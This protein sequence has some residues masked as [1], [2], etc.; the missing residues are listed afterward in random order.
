[1][2]IKDQQKRS[3]KQ[4][5]SSV[6]MRF[7]TTTGILAVAVV[8]L[9]I[10]FFHTIRGDI[11]QGAFQAP[12]KD[13]SA[14]IAGHIGADLTKA[15]A[16]A[17]THRIGI[18]IRT[19][20]GDH[21]FG[22]DGEPVEA[23]ELLKD[24]SRFRQ[25]NVHIQHAAEHGG[26]NLER[27]YTFMLDK[28]DFDDDR[29]PLLFGLI[30]LLLFTIGLAYIMQISLLRPLKWLR[31]GVEAVSEGD[32]S[33]KV[34]V[35]RNDEI[36]KVARAFNQMTTRVQQ[37]M[38]DRER[39][40]A[41][42]SHE[43]RSPL[44]RMKVALELLPEGDKHNAIARDIREMEALTTALL[45]REQMRTK[46]QAG[47]QT[48]PSQSNAETINLIALT[49]DVVDGFHNSIPAVDLVVPPQSLE[50]RGDKAL[51]KILIQNLVDNAIKFSLADS[52]P[53]IVTLSQSDEGIH[54]VVEDDGPG[55]PADQVEKVFEP[56][57]KLDP[58]RGHRS[59]YGLG[60]N[61]CQRIVQAQG[62]HIEIQ[63]RDGRG[64]RVIVSLPRVLSPMSPTA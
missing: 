8:I 34:P 38:D 22:P 41:D 4:A 24:T 62:G 52:E 43:L 58:A 50:I 11:F 16:V 23:D 39:L 47:I 9:A 33:I 27:H 1:M 26:D 44:A 49:G 61:L 6:I 53:V 56:F 5:G 51:I 36:G 3:E 60:L 46:I 7:A 37:M 29:T 45:E 42:V 59:G 40:L 13:W 35:V 17:K 28:E 30:F 55:I 12:L 64:I 18:V 32:F 25:I 48:D 57:V 54:I 20:D 15:Q 19:E 31:G 14:T 10:L 21:A 63:Q 2:S